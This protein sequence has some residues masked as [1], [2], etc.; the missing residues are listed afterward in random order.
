MRRSAPRSTGS[1]SSLRSRSR[2]APSSVRP[3]FAL[4]PFFGYAFGPDRRLLHRLRRQRDRRPDL[5]LGPADVLELEHRERSRRLH[6]RSRAAVPRPDGRGQRPPA[7][8]RWRDRRRRSASLVGFL[9]VFTDILSGARRRDDPDDAVHPG[10]RRRPDRDVILVPIL[11]YAWEPVKDRSGVDEP[12][13]PPRREHR[14]ALSGPGIVARPPRS[15]RP[16][17]GRRAVHLHRPS[18]SGTGGSIV[19]LL[20]S[21]AALLPHG[22]DP[23]RGTSAGTGSSSSRSSAISCS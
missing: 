4:V 23:V 16:H 3:A 7:S 14:S 11:V 22:R 8:H 1:C 15:P 12:F 21:R 13:R 18:R 2:G 5:R 20:G 6:R 9:F 19:A 17:P 10:R